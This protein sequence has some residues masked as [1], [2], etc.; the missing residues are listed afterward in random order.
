MPERR[1]KKQTGRET[2]RE[3]A[4]VLVSCSPLKN[5]SSSCSCARA[6]KKQPE[7]GQNSLRR[8][9]ILQTRRHR[10]SSH[11]RGRAARR[12]RTRRSRGRRRGRGAGRDVSVLLVRRV[13]G[14]AGAAPPGG[15]ALPVLPQGPPRRIRGDV[16][17]VRGG[18]AGGA[19]EGC[20]GRGEER[21]RRWWRVGREGREREREREKRL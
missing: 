2:E 6:L 18:A 8:G 7:T 19:G 9:R 5:L 17:G 20:V 10:D 1:R 15:L 21:Q 14:R 16:L 11:D 3:R 13:G 12:R 4:S